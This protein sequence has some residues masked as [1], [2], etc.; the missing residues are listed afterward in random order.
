[1]KDPHRGPLSY[2]KETHS[3]L[4]FLAQY[5]VLVRIYSMNLVTFFSS[6][7]QLAAEQ[8]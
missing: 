8:S 1:M 6:Y 3:L 2:I 5:S 7:W 4:K